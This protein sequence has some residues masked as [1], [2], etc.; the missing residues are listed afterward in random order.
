MNTLGT[1]FKVTT[2]GES[3]GKANMCIISGCPA[4]LKLTEDELNVALC[5][6]VPCEELGTPRK[7]TNKV[8][9][10]SGINEDG[11]TLGTSIGIVIY[12]SSQKKKDYSHLKGIYR[13][14][15]AE[16]TYHERYGVYSESGGGRASGR[17][18]ISRLA[19]GAIAN[20]IL[21]KVGVIIDSS[22]EEMAGVCLKDFG[23]ENAKK[24]CMEIGENGDSTGGIIK[25]TVKGVPAGIGSP[26]FGKL[27]AA[28]CHALK[29]IGGTKGVEVGEGFQSARMKGS[30]FNDSIILE[31][32]KIKFISNNAGGFLGGISTGDD[33][34]FKISIKPTPSF[35]IPQKTVN[36]QKNQN[37]KLDI[38]G[39]FDMNF[40]PRVGPISE[41]MAALVLVDHLMISGIINPRRITEC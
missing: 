33:M 27:D 15:H 25:L 8:E 26:I 7:E 32:E 16:F 1:I 19:A 40:T 22:I 17:E 3:H 18:C 41:A 35:S 24:K 4:G 39:R 11:I 29:T 14:G 31:K 28:I 5:R 21:K 13:P 6:D 2:A 9:I 10:L 30:Q 12:N 36:W 20:K 34:I 38:K 23:F 37:Q